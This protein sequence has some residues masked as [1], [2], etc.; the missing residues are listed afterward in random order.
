MKLEEKKKK[1]CP[2]LELSLKQIFEADTEMQCLWVFFLFQC[3]GRTT[4]ENNLVG[5][6]VL[7][8]LPAVTKNRNARN[9]ISDSFFTRLPG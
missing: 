2:A 7:V 5:H 6:A 8:K 3:L 9:L 4:H 1:V